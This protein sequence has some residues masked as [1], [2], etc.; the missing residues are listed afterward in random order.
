MLKRLTVPSPLELMV[1]GGPLLK[2]F[3]F[4]RLLASKI[5]HVAFMLTCLLMIVSTR[6]DVLFF[7]AQWSMGN[8][9]VGFVTELYSSKTT[10]AKVLVI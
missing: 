2:V 7:L 4:Q 10:V 5:D 1:F 3:S 6:Q 8:M 9:T